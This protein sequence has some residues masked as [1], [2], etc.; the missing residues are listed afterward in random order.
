MV[1]SETKKTRHSFHEV[2]C[3]Q[4]VSLQWLPQAGGARC[5]WEGKKVKKK[6]GWEE[7]R[8]GQRRG[9]CQPPAS[10][11]YQCEWSVAARAMGLIRALLKET[12]PCPPV[13]LGGCWSSIP[14]Y[15]Q[16]AFFPSTPT[17]SSQQW[18]TLQKT[19]LLHNRGALTQWH[20]TQKFWRR[21]NICF[22]STSVCPTIFFSRL[23]VREQKASNVCRTVSVLKYS[24]RTEKSH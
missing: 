17:H 3:Q 24:N 23:L 2:L 8:R 20:S 16:P 18:K 15:R 6:R 21:R 19:L 14:H 7:R 5:R 22:I 10:S 12:R 13:P 9:A 1:I 11:N 4:G